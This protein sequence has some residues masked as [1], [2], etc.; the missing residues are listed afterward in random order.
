MLSKAAETKQAI[1]QAAAS[2]STSKS[3]LGMFSPQFQAAKNPKGIKPISTD[4]PTRK[5]KAVLPTKLVALSCD[6]DSSD[7]KRK[8]A[9]PPCR[10]HVFPERKPLQ[11]SKDSKTKT[12][13]TAAVAPL[14]KPR[15]PPITTSK[16]LITPVTSLSQQ[17]NPIFL[18][19][20]SLQGNN[21]IEGVQN[22]NVGGLSLVTLQA[23][24]NFLNCFRLNKAPTN[25]AGP[26]GQWVSEASNMMDTHTIPL[27]FNIKNTENILQTSHQTSTSSKQNPIVSDCLSVQ[28]EPLNLKV[29]QTS[30]V[31]N[32]SKA[33]T[34]KSVFTQA[35]FLKPVTVTYPRVMREEKGQVSVGKHGPSGLAKDKSQQ[36]T[37][38][39]LLR[40]IAQAKS[41]QQGSRLNALSRRPSKHL[42]LSTTGTRKRQ[43]NCP[44]PGNLLLVFAVRS[45][46]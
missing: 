38:R 27:Q 29:G 30:T 42:T 31:S 44:S 16:T 10:S 12:K 39:L 14:I 8:V 17:G 26:N 33:A 4:K 11:L 35:R 1:P 36:I 21:D 34:T 9:T 6:E 7:K 40:N 18:L 23:P 25:P 28:L 20:V 13:L 46:N 22:R 15:L 5:R 37:T 24:P 19:P 3:K 43:S 32:R 45:F 2:K 41:H